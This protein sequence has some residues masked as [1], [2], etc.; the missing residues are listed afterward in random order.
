[1]HFCI[2]TCL[3]GQQLFRFGESNTLEVFFR[4]CSIWFSY[5]CVTVSILCKIIKVNLGVQEEMG[6]DEKVHVFEEV[7][8]HN[9]TKDCWLIMN[10]K[11]RSLVVISCQWGSMSLNLV[12]LES[13]RAFFYSSL[14]KL[15][16]NLHIQMNYQIS[17]LLKVMLIE[18]IEIVCNLGL[19]FVLILFCLN[20]CWIVCFVQSQLFCNRVSTLT[21]FF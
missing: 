17:G 1:M 16:I 10:G 4:E 14:F 6:S 21:S 5:L 18:V 8:K 3:F 11:V 2:S 20:R 15:L 12:I 19:P 13:W 7:A 9:K